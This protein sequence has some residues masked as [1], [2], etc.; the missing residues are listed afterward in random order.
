MVPKVFFNH[1][2]KGKLVTMLVITRA[3]ARKNGQPSLLAEN[4]LKK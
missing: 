2:F 4:V 1:F 3:K